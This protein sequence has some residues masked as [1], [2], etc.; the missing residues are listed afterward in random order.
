MGKGNTVSIPLSVYT[1][2]MTGDFMICMGMSKN[3]AWIG[4]NHTMA[5]PLIPKEQRAVSY[6]CS[7]ADLGVQPQMDAVHLGDGMDQLGL[8][9]TVKV[10]ECFLFIEYKRTK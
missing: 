6:V 10:F 9:V 4:M 1:F 7:A 8:V 2:Q 3:G 5:M